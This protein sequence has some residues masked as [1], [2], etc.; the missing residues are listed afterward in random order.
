MNSLIV[1]LSIL[2]GADNP[3]DG[4]EL[5]VEAV[6][7]IRQSAQADGRLLLDIV[8]LQIRSGETES[9]RTSLALFIQK[10]KTRTAGMPTMVVLTN[11]LES[12]NLDSSQL[13]LVLSIIGKVSLDDILLSTDQISGIDNLKMKVVERLADEK[14]FE[15]AEKMFATM[16]LSPT[17][18]PGRDEEIEYADRILLYAANHLAE[19]YIDSG[20]NNRGLEVISR[21]PTPVAR[22]IAA[23]TI[24]GYAL[25]KGIS[26]DL[27]ETH[28]GEPSEEVQLAWNQT[29]LKVA[30][31]GSNKNIALALDA[32]HHIHRIQG[33][34]N[35]LCSAKVAMLLREAGRDTEARRILIDAFAG[36]DREPDTY[37]GYHGLNLLAI[38]LHE[39]G[40][41]EKAVSLCAHWDRNVI[42]RRPTGTV[43]DHPLHHIA[44]ELAERNIGDALSIAEQIQDDYW[45]VSTYRDVADVGNRDHELLRHELVDLALADAR[46]VVQADERDSLVARL[47]GRKAELI[48]ADFDQLMDLQMSIESFR[49]RARMLAPQIRRLIVEKRVDSNQIGLA[50]EFI[51]MHHVSSLQDVVDGL[52]NQGNWELAAET[53]L[54]IDSKLKSSWNMS[55]LQRF[56]EQLAEAR[57]FERAVSL[58]DQLPSRVR[59]T[60]ILR[61][62]PTVNGSQRRELVRRALSSLP[63][64]DLN[65][66]LYKHLFQHL[67][68]ESDWESLSRL[69]QVSFS[70]SEDSR[71]VQ[72]EFESQILAAIVDRGGDSIDRLQ[73]S[74]QS[75]WAGD[76]IVYARIKA[77]LESG[78]IDSAMKQIRKLEDPHVRAELTFA[79]ASKLR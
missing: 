8:A 38:Q 58:I 63:D 35:A 79:A 77:E 21:F 25:K 65:P 31:L 54:K 1:A 68:H 48:D 18:I 33:Q 7:L 42:K 49:N 37:R 55:R 36:C 64:Q 43:K 11:Y 56:L 72:S 52:V 39:I 73:A 67:I 59:N 23:S 30:V 9:A 40:E 2:I 20:D 74:I 75:D 3:H 44:I 78:D 24:G 32:L 16:S 61:M 12:R 45:R 69:T 17:E 76:A 13:E 47:I 28:L 10:S 57:G 29:K 62:L 60:A 22:S 15:D 51:E 4:N 19:A 6:D 53:I 66:R 14:R 41:T 70:R 5:L 71:V 27:I 50:I 26:S 46:H 34:P